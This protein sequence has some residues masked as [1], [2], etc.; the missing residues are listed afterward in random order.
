MASIRKLSRDKGKKN[1]PY[2]IQ[3]TDAEG[4][5]ITIKGFTDK[6]LTEQL[7]AKLENEV[8]LRKRGM[9]DPRRRGYWPSSSLRSQTIWRRSNGPC[10]TRRRSTRS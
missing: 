7:A 5:R 1:R 8:L 3:Y 10:P 4:N 9:I 6:A 2:Y